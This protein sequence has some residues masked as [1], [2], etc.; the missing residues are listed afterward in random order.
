[1]LDWYSW[2]MVPWKETENK[3]QDDKAIS[4]KVHISLM[5]NAVVM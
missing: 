4:A 5:S 3:Q 2:N 1:M